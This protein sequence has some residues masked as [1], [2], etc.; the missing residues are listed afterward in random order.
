[1]NKRINTNNLNY[2]I[3]GISLV[4]SLLFFNLDIYSALAVSIFMYWVSSLFIRTN[5][6]LPI[7][8]LFL[9]MYALQFLLGP[10]MAYNGMDYYTDDIYKMKVSSQEYFSYILPVFIAFAFGFII[11]LK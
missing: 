4:L 3:V 7:K 6:S 2:L 1:M 10:T 9:S 11:P 5:N 8:E